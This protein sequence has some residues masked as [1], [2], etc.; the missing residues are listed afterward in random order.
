MND[1]SFEEISST[2]RSIKW[3]DSKLLGAQICRADPDQK[4]YDVDLEINARTDEPTSY[5]LKKVSFK[6]TRVIKL[7]L[8]FLGLIICGGDIGDANCYKD[9]VAMEKKFRDMQREFDFPEGFL[10]F[11]E[12]FACFI[13]MIHPAGNLLIFARNLR[14]DPSSYTDL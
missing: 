10:P 6:E 5:V 1:S 12:T 8:D 14:I 2:F 3:H 11:D 9:A 7:D 13:E 4:L